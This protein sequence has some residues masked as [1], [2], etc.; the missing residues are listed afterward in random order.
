MRPVLQN[1]LPT[2]HLDLNDVQVELF[3]SKEEHMMQLYC[4]RYLSNTYRF[5]PRMMR[6]CYANPPIS[7]LSKILTKIA[8]E[9]ARMVLCSPN[10]GTTREDA[11]YRWLLDHMTVERTELADGPIYVNEAPYHT[12]P[13]PE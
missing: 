2:L 6:M 10:W 11:Y 13:V 3:E 7:Q 8:L 9:G 1:G 4:S 12:K 5:H